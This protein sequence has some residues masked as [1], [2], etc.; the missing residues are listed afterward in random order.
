MSYTGNFSQSMSIALATTFNPRGETGRLM[1]L[2]PQLEAIY[3][4]RIV[5]LPPTTPTEEI[6]RIESLPGM[7]VFSNEDWAHG[8]FTALNAAYEAG[9]DFIHYVDMDR[10]I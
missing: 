5:S 9:A 8:R 10:L 6:R 4:H 7:Q 3:S 1:Q 2:Y